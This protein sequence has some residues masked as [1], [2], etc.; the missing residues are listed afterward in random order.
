MGSY[1]PF[2]LRDVDKLTD[3]RTPSIKYQNVP[4]IDVAKIRGSPQYLSAMRIL[5]E[6]GEVTLA[7][8][9]SSLYNISHFFETRLT[10]SRPAVEYRLP[11]KLVT[12]TLLSILPNLAPQNLFHYAPYKSSRSDYLQATP[13]TNFARPFR[14]KRGNT[15][16]R[17]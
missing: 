6:D 15:G 7:G 1:S 13:L 14:P 10:F 11:A 12:F 9:T 17:P 8:H 5:A 16:C 2:A 4:F 3:Y